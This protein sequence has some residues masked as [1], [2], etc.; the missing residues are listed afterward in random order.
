MAPLIKAISKYRPRIMLG[1][2]ANAQRFLEI[3]TQRTTLSTGVVKNVQ[4]S[5]V[6]TL[7]GLL[8]EGR[9]VYT[10]TAIFT[11]TVDLEGN[12]EVSVRL[13]KRILA[14]LNSP[15]AFAGKISNSA[16]IGK[17]SQEIAEM[18]NLEYAEDPVVI[19]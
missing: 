10:G 13:D 11:P 8:K 9:S 15:K 14:A 2:P 1:K 3:I 16:N 7:T 19:Q 4:E 18:W 12:I 5:E 6:E 17:T